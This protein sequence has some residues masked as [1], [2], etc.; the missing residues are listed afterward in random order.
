MSIN[1]ESFC[2][3]RTPCTISRFGSLAQSA[4]NTPPGPL[5]KYIITFASPIPIHDTAV[6][7]YRVIFRGSWA[8]FDIK[9]FLD[10]KEVLLGYSVQLY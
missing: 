7:G 3:F 10:L 8:P 2:W 9:L 4:K 1:N 6:M 5:K